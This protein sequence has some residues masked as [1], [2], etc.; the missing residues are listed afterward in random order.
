MIVV[1]S[2]SGTLHVHILAR[3]VHRF[4]LG[5]HNAAREYSITCEI[6]LD[7]ASFGRFIRVQNP[8]TYHNYAALNTASVVSNSESLAAN[9][10]I[11]STIA[12][13][14]IWFGQE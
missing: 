6:Q 8:I 10:A 3:L 7:I 1:Q 2:H 14:T 9:I 11:R 13:Q 5:V 12:L 4:V